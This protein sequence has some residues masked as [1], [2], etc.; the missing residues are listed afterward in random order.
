MSDDD[1]DFPPNLHAINTG[2][3]DTHSDGAAEFVH[4]FVVVVY[5]R[6]DDDTLNTK[7]KTNLVSLN[8]LI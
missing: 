7:Q 5:Q 4:I 1:D 8:K 2:R 3:P 6:F